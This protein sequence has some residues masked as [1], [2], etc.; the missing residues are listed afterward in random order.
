MHGFSDPT[1][2]PH[3]SS[4]LHQHVNDVALVL[5]LNCLKNAEVV[6]SLFFSAKLSKILGYFKLI[7]LALQ[8]PPQVIPS[9]KQWTILES[10]K[11][12]SHS[13]YEYCPRE[14]A[15]ECGACVMLD[16]TFP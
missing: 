5:H 7:P 13:F 9:P 16:D 3:G 14:L 6:V 12:P 1:W 4:I 10:I 2:H 8:L 11:D 15:A